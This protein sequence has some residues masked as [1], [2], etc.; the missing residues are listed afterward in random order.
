MNKRHK[1]KSANHRHLIQKSS[2]PKPTDQD[3]DRWLGRL[4]AVAFEG[5]Q[6][7]GPGAVL[8]TR[9]RLAYASAEEFAIIAPELAPALAGL[10]ASCTPNQFVLMLA[11]GDQ[12]QLM[13]L[14]APA[15]LAELHRQ[16]AKTLVGAIG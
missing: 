12:A 10:L 2:F 4:A 15:P 1:P 6:Q 14:D 7:L 5:K 11:S 13:V 3:I 16:W 8:Q 9:T